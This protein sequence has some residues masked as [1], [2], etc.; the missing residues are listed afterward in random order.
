MASKR[1]TLVTTLYRVERRG[2]T[3]MGNP[4]FDF[5]TEHGTL[6]MQ[7]NASI[8]YSVPNDFY[9]GTIKQEWRDFN[10]AGERDY[11]PMPVMVEFTTTPAGRV[12]AYRIIGPVAE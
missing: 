9:M 3:T 2:V 8:G 5:I 1:N 4:R 10:G 11:R 7:S 6:P 12:T